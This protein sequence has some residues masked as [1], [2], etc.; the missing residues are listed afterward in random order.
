M[1]IFPTNQSVNQGN[2]AQNRDA[3]APFRQS[4]ALSANSDTPYW[5]N[6]NAYYYQ[7]LER[8][9]RQHIPENA[10]VL[11]IGCG[12]GDLL[13]ELKPAN[14]VG[15][16]TNAADVAYAQAKYP[17]LT[18]TLGKPESFDADGQ[19]DYVV[20]CNAIG[21]MHDIQAALHRA[22]AACRAETRLLIA[23][24]NPLWAPILNLAAAI[25]Q[26]QPVEEQNWLS[27]ADIENLLQLADF[28]VIRRR[29]ELLCPKQIPLISTFCNRFLAR[30]WPFSKCALVTFTVARPVIRPAVKPNPTCS[31]V[32]PTHNERGNIE[33][34]IRRT[35]EMGA[36]TEII[37]VDG[38][39]TDGTSDEIERVHDA[40]P[41]RNIRLIH[42]GD[43]RGKGD[44]VRK[45]FAAATGDILMILDAD[46]TVA[47]ED[48]PKFYAA[49]K[50][51]RGEFING[52]RLVYP[53]EQQAMRTLNKAGNRFFSR[54][55]SCLL[56]QRIR[57]TLCG[58]KVLWKKDYERIARDRAYFGQLDPFGDFDLI[59]GAAKADFRILE[60]PVR[61]RARTYGETSIRRFRDGLLL[62][63]MSWIA[64]CKLKFR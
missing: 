59:L 62:L 2:F 44:A 52:T 1:P 46:L 11:E 49:I 54:V 14:G 36:A 4:A 33:E 43:G 40:Y 35:P 26:R 51:G 10:S 24:F 57:D 23:Y 34:A 3:D 5:R 28:E 60:L 15:V 47:P 21:E 17:E 55:F 39:S 30:L 41:E 6:K 42:Q 22:H 16:S 37:F 18:F 56:G 64:L 50:S 29:R 13:A 58:T 45:G 12:R 19:F 53:M 48:L 27:M 61:Y 7:Q 8:L 25:G 63:R 32:I 38:H 20:V 31:V 9:F